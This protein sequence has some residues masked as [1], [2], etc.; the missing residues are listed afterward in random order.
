MQ[1][2][3]LGPLLVSGER[4]V[5]AVP[6]A[7]Q[8]VLL[9]WLLTRANQVVPAQTLADIV[10]DGS[11][12][13]GAT[14]TLRTYV[15]RLRH[16]LGATAGSRVVTHHPGYL[17]TVNAHELDLLRFDALCHAGRV[18]AQA[19][20]WRQAAHLLG[21]A[22]ALWRGT[23]LVDVPS[24]ALQHSEVPVLE[25]RRLQAVEWRIDADAQLLRHGELVPELQS[26]VA[27][28]PLRE[29]F[30]EQLMIALYHCGRQGEALA[31]YRQ[32]RRALV[33]ELGVEPGRDLQEAHQRILTADPQL[34]RHE[35]AGPAVT[36]APPP[37]PAVP[38]PRGWPPGEHVPA[39]LAVPRQLPAAVRHF[40]GRDEE[41][42][43]L[44]ALLLP[45]AGD[46]DRALAPA[47]CV[48]GGMAGAGKTALAVHW[49]HRVADRFPD[50]QLYADLHGYGPTATP[51]DC[52]EAIRGFLT[53]LAV[54]ASR[55]P[56]SLPDAA[57]LY[58]SLLAGKRVLV[59]LD[60]ARDADQVRPLLP[61]HP[62]SLAL[63]T[64]RSPLAGLAVAQDA[65][66]LPLGLLN[67]GD[68]R[69]LL[70]ARLGTTRAAA[71][72]AALARLADLCAG[73]PLALA[74]TATRAAT[75]PG[76]PLAILAAELHDAS[77][78]LDALDPGDPSTSVRTSFWWSYRQL[79]NQAAR[80]FRLLGTHSG[81]VITLPT[82]A[83]LSGLATGAAL[84]ALREL[85]D[86]CLLAEHSPG[87]YTCHD[88][89]HAYA[90]EQ[91][92]AACLPGALGLALSAV[93]ATRWQCNSD[94]ALAH[95]RGRPRDAVSSA[96]RGDAADRP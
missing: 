36:L 35:V 62:G 22:L 44:E 58:R 66:L 88:L 55:I 75:R 33:S 93:Q 87:R 47:V 71:E 40:V 13:E 51:L 77:T 31:V 10:W 29:R 67:P 41:M 72:P 24:Q 63:I 2:G 76:H 27:E 78:C 7:R 92:N 61:G 21:E 59:V 17:V 12:P 49:A 57:A 34:T 53:A 52:G 6:A 3:I 45:P 5:V 23:P 4:G 95:N 39:L 1:F 15:M 96:G 68:A 26:L 46:S 18:A 81:S 91:A 74:V 86:A 89:I 16:A 90:T 48:I 28:Y 20:S 83:S 69:R 80:M 60:N 42:R 84:H 85:H 11:P 64:S 32:A 54:P 79:S 56:A 94:E 50:A 37:Q 65:T 82:A 19:G 8:R 38:A 14:S 73:L 25:Q 9:A 30:Y 43:A 70:T